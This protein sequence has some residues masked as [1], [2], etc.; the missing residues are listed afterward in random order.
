MSRPVDVLYL[1]TTWTVGGT[2]T[3]LLNLLR[4]LDRARFRPHVCSLYADP[5]LDAAM[6][7]LGVTAF[8]LGVRRMRYPDTALRLRSLVAYCRRHRVRVIQGVRTDQVALVV[9]RLAGVPVV[10]GGQR[11]TEW[12]AGSRWRPVRAMLDRR[13]TGVVANSQAAAGYRA[14][15][16]RLAPE[17]LHVVPNG[18]D[19]ERYAAPAPLSRAGLGLPADAPLLALVGRLAVETKGHLDLLRAMGEPGLEACR[20]LVVGD[21]PDRAR[22]ERAVA[23][24]GL[25]G[26]VALAG[27]RADVEALFGLADIAVMASRHESSPNVILEAWAA[28]RPVVATR[29]GGVPELVRDGADGLLVPP[30]DPPALAA[31]LRALLADPALARR[32]GEAGRARVYADYT[33]AAMARRVGA[34]Y[35]RLLAGGRP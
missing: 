19:L 29:V 1:L 24:L 12:G 6:A 30:G 13:L 18:L 16:S 9:G 27:H 3:Q 20:L 34:L 10:L 7:P 31:A 22:L 35:E 17:R 25:A 21:G 2:E 32:L 4:H 14:A 33:A 15:Y 11:D 28:G 5:R 23:D 26:R 8:S